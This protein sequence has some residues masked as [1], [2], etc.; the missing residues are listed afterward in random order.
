MLQ[1]MD[2][3][4]SSFFTSCA[5]HIFPFS[6]SS[7]TLSFCTRSRRMFRRI[8]RSERPPGKRPLYP[9][10]HESRSA[11]KRC[12]MCRPHTEVHPHPPAGRLHFSGAGGLPFP[13]VLR[14]TSPQLLPLP[15]SL[16]IFRSPKSSSQCHIQHH[17]HAEAHRKKYHTNVG[18]LSLQHFRD[19]FL[20]HHIQHGSGKKVKNLCSPCALLRLQRTFAVLQGAL[21]GSFCKPGGKV[22]GIPKAH[23][24]CNFTD[25]VVGEDKQF[26]CLCNAEVDEVII[27]CRAHI[28]PKQP[29]K[30][31]F[32]S[33]SLGSF[34]PYADFYKAASVDNAS[35]IDLRLC[36]F[37]F[38]R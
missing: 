32:A 16:G 30:I 29:Q 27:R 8:S 12:Q 38:Q 23:F 5:S 15:R 33:V 9:G 37:S 7:V 6:S 28:P 34:I 19:Q 25:A 36:Y 2:R 10:A 31:A 18:V 3:F 35:E 4:V 1:R 13:D 21:P 24:L 14:D 26:L 17:H 22:A 11:T 20:H